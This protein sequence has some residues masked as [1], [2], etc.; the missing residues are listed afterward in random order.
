ML[1]TDRQT[2]AQTDADDRY[3]HATH[4]NVRNNSSAVMTFISEMLS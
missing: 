4:V 2:D 1:W 3:T